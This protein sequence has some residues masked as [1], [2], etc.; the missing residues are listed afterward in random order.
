MASAFANTL[1]RWWYT[2]RIRSNLLTTVLAVA[3]LGTALLAL[4]AAI[5]LA[6]FGRVDGRAD[7]AAR[8]AP[9]SPGA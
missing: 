2:P 5:P 3:M 8:S 6:A 7:R 9:R 1:R 4:A